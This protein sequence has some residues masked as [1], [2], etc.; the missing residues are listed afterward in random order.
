MNYLLTVILAIVAVSLAMLCRRFATEAANLRGRFS[1]ITDVDAELSAVKCRLEQ[2]NK[3][4]QNL[5]AETEHKREK[6]SQEYERALS[7]YNELKKEVSLLEENLDDISFGV[8]KPHFNYDTPDE[9][10]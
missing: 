8:Y 5:E 6:L 4:K 7:T 3:E 1:G 9:Y 2:A 10:K